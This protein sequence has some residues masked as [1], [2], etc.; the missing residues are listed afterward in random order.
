M[1]G[2]EVPISMIYAPAQ[3]Q[4]VSA[5][6]QPLSRILAKDT[7]LM[8]TWMTCLQGNRLGQ[9]ARTAFEQGAASEHTEDT[10]S[11]AQNTVSETA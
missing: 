4:S 1:Y 7:G 5:D 3:W 6:D 10:G 8:R 9:D 2:E 11:Q